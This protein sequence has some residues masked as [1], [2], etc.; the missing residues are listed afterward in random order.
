MEGFEEVVG[1]GFEVVDEGVP[2][3]D[4]AEHS[5]LV[6]GL[7]DGAFAGVDEFEFGV[8]G[9]LEDFGGGVVGL[10]HGAHAVG[11]A[12]AAAGEQDARFAG[13][14]RVAVGHETEGVLVTTA[15]ESYGILLVVESVVNIH[16]MGGDDT[17]NGIHPVG[18]QALHYGFS[19]G[20]Q[21]HRNTSNG[22]K[23]V[24]LCRVAG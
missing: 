15:Y 22:L 8:G 19:A 2:A 13:D 4:G 17:E 16:G 18:L 10:A 21:R 20:H 7:V 3:G 23:L 11:G 14:S 9:D 24:E 6:F 1:Q 5:E 12:G